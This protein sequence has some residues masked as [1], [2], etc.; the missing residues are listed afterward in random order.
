MYTRELDE[1][2]LF[3]FVEARGIHSGLCI[4]E[5]FNGNASNRD[6]VPW[7]YTPNGEINNEY[8]A[9]CAEQD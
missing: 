2:I 4:A 9:F 8:L 7:P 3:G 1:R 5:I 6:D